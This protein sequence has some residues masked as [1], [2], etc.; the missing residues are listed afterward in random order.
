MEDTLLPGDRIVVRKDIDTRQITRNDIIVFKYPPDPSKI[1]I[2][3]CVGLPGD[4]LE[5]FD[6]VLSINGKTAKEADKIKYTDWRIC[7]AGIEQKGIYPPGSGNRD[8]YGP[9]VLPE[10]SLF[11]MGDNRDNSNDSR[12]WGFV[13]LDYIIG[14][15]IFIYFS[16]DPHIPIYRSFER[17]RWRRIG[18]M[19]QHDI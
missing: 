8:N 14:K 16:V 13:P 10:N 4:T 12:Y 1:Y 2:S 7:P 15:P 18:Y 11:V 6:K 9:V 19:A 17:I 3:R 5:I